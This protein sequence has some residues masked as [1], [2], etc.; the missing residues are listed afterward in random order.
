M[1]SADPPRLQAS[2][3][4]VSTYK[5]QS[6]GQVPSQSC[7][8]VSHN[9][10][11][12]PAVPHSSFALSGT[13]TS[14]SWIAWKLSKEYIVTYFCMFFFLIDR[15]SSGAARFA[16]HCCSGR[17]AFAFPTL[18][19]YSNNKKNHHWLALV[20]PSVLWALFSPASP[21]LLA[22]CGGQW[23]WGIGSRHL[24]IPVLTSSICSHIHR[25]RDRL[26]ASWWSSYRSPAV[27]CGLTY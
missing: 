12:E 1:F 21:S 7:K 15:S 9:V 16:V 25:H 13:M 2:S 17:T 4:D 11:W 22:D 6:P 8:A 10:P 19:A 24:G 20:L 5:Q 14:V 3:E 26:K 23:D 18:M 27:V